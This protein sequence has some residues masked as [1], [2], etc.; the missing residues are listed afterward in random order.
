MWSRMWLPYSSVRLRI[1]S[2]EDYQLLC[3]KYLSSLPGIYRERWF[4]HFWNS[5]FRRQSS[6][7]Q[8]RPSKRK[9]ILIGQILSKTS[10]KVLF[11]SLRNTLLSYSV[12]KTTQKKRTIYYCI[13]VRLQQY[14]SLHW[15]PVRNRILTPHFFSLDLGWCC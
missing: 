4:Y 7:F 15:S 12:F 13:I 14:S 3:R 11:M 1:L 8:L 2:W 5:Y 9:R 10:W 6:G